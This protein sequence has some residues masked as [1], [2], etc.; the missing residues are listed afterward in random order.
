MSVTV[1]VTVNVPAPGYANTGFWTVLSMTESPSKSHSH[2]V[3]VPSSVDSSVNCTDSPDAGFTGANEKS[4]VGAPTSMIGTSRLV[5]SVRTWVSVTVRVTRN[6]PLDANVWFGFWALLV[7]PSPK[8]QCHATTA[9]SA[10][11]D[12][13]VNETADPTSCSGGL[14][15]KLATGRTRTGTPASVS[16]PWFP[17]WSV[18][19]SR[20]STLPDDA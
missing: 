18:T 9:A 17:A 2:A 14:K 19:V 1:R 12:R 13:S 10:S 8:S 3:M 7:E 20:I 5:E 6:E 15:E 4:A 16:S 11:V